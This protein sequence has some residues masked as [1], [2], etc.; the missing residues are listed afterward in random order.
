LGGLVGATM[1]PTYSAYSGYL[2]GSSGCDGI[3]GL[4]DADTTYF[5]LYT[6]TA[7]PQFTITASVTLSF[8]MGGQAA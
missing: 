7:E 6:A 3:P 1:Q 5:P 8:A 4:E 2:A